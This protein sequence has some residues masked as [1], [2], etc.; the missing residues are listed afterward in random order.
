M[1]CDP[2]NSACSYRHSFLLMLF[3]LLAPM[4]YSLAQDN[5]WGFG[6]DIGVWTGRPT[7][8]CLRWGWDST[9]TWTQ[10]FVR[11]LGPVYPGLGT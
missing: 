6:T 7:S 11:W 2:V 4:E 5:R 9:I 10:I 8:Q 3:L 1:S